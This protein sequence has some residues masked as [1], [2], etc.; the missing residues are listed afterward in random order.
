[1]Y[2]Y[3]H[4]ALKNITGRNKGPTKAYTNLAFPN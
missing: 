3:H 2:G 1:M 4:E